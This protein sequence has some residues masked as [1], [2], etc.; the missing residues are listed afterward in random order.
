[1][2]KQP[3][4]VIFVLLAGS[5]IAVL[6]QTLINPAL[7]TIMAEMGVNATTAQ[8][9]VSGFTLVNAIVIAI[10]AFLMDR[11]PIK[12]LF[13]TIFIFFIAG[14][15]LS[16]WGVD[17]TMLLCGRILQAICVGVMLPLSMTVLLL[18]APREKRGSAMGLY[19][20]IIMFAPAS[21]PVISGVLTDQVGWRIMFLIMAALAT[22]II[23]A[24]AI[25]MK[26]SG[27]PK[28]VTLDKLSVT[29][30]SAGL[31]CLLYSFSL[32]G[33]ATQQPAVVAALIVAGAA[34]LFVFVR[35]QFKLEQPFLHIDVLQNK[36]FATGIV[37]SMLI[38]ASLAASGIILPIYIQTLRGFSA[39]MTGA[40]MM[41][42]ALAGAV[43]GY[44]AG[45]LHDRFGARYVAIAGVSLVTLG[46]IG[47]AMFDF[48][49]PVS[50]M[51]AS[52][53]ALIIGLMLAGTPINAWSIS[54]LHDDILHHGNAVSSTLRQVSSSL[55][56]AIMVSVMS[57]VS[58]LYAPGL[59][60]PAA[61]MMGVR[62]TYLISAAIGLTALIIVIIK[63]K[64]GRVSVVATEG[65]SFEIDVAMKFDPYTVSS[66]DTLEQ[67]ISKF[68]EFRTSGLPVV[69]EGKRVVGFISDGDILRHMSRHDVSF[70]TESYS[71]LLPDTENFTEKAK[72]LMRMNI[73]E[74]ASKRIISVP[75]HTPLLDVCNQFFEQKLNKLPVTQDGVLVG[76]ISRGDVMRELMK[77]LPLV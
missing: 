38:L 45:R 17:F 68:I 7:P 69:D 62:A 75:R 5:F 13:I 61:Q 27:E 73:M 14:S 52:Y 71:M 76:T 21:G 1:M 51:T 55:T 54:S 56:I 40:I 57:Y 70:V 74:I 41:P 59:S 26:D 39:T 30:S 77:Q 44:F 64:K 32:L 12:K 60:E 72:T 28:P 65:A 29:L 24:A 37:V 48:R 50:F 46:S 22:A 58:G 16:G 6:N 34:M 49:T 4:R 67:A 20:F 63:V 42:G 47:M 9:L 36:R 33:D 3:Q 31:F 10:S 43:C 53:G 35:R 23:L 66:G 11:F 18:N 15:L 25:I 8:W 19:S 2:T